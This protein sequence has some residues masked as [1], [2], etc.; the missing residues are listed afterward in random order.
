M[1][2]V[3]EYA[4]YGVS[5]AIASFVLWADKRREFPQPEEV[6]E[7]FK[8]APA[9]AHRWLNVYEEASGKARPRRGTSGNLRAA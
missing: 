7:R 8:C 1:K 5:V 6:I 9:T 2:T 4:G 3:H